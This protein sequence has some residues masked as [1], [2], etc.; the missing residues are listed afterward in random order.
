MSVCECEYLCVCGGASVCMSI[1]LCICVGL[2]LSSLAG[3]GHCKSI[4]ST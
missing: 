2:H 4:N 1:Y 3:S